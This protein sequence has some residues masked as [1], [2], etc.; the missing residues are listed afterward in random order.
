M[1]DNK[2]TVGPCIWEDC[3]R[4]GLEDVVLL[5]RMQNWVK[6]RWRWLSLEQLNRQGLVA[7]CGEHR[8]QWAELDAGGWG[9]T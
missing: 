3:L 4:S 7:L 1:T 5:P 6:E 9:R 8:K 2:P